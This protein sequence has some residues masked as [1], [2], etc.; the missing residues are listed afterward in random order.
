MNTNLSF[1]HL[2]VCH[3]S[4]QKPVCTAFTGQLTQLLSAHSLWVSIEA[5]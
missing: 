3:P 5:N 1:A 4:E 2:Y